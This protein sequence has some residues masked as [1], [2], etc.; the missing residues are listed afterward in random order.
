M[1][2]MWG[3]RWQCD[4]DLRCWHLLCRSLSGRQVAPPPPNLPNGL[5]SAKHRTGVRRCLLPRG[6]L[7][8][9][10]LSMCQP[11]C[12]NFIT[13]NCKLRVTRLYCQHWKS[14]PRREQS[15]FHITSPD[16]KCRSKKNILMLLDITRRSAGECATCS[17]TVGLACWVMLRGSRGTFPWCTPLRLL[18]LS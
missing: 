6:T 18:S 14:V 13:C 5:G 16:L 15:C 10:F 3:G 8:W 4:K 17:L 1:S 11:N 2:V 9:D 12:S 7:R